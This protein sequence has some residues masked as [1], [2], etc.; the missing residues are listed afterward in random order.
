MWC[1]CFLVDL[2]K[3]IGLVLLAFDQK[4]LHGIVDI[5]MCVL[6]LLPPV[7]CYTYTRTPV[8]KQASGCVGPNLRLKAPTLLDGFQPLWT[9]CKLSSLSLEAEN[10]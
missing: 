3:P 6:L 5:G 7:A 8:R 9:K 1:T 2:D 10:C 4:S